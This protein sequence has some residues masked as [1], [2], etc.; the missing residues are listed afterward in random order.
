MDRD[1]A[2]QLLVGPA[3]AA[4]YGDGPDAG[5][6]RG[7]D[8]IGGVPHHEDACLRQVE[9]REG[10][11]DHPRIGLGARGIGRGHP[12][13]DQVAHPCDA[14]QLREVAGFRGAGHDHAQAPCAQLLDE[15]TRSAERA[16]T[17]QVLASEEPAARA[18]R[19]LPDGRVVTESG[20]A[21]EE[22]VSAHADELAHDPVG[23][24]EAV[25]AQG[26]A[27]RARVLIV[28]VDEGPVDVEHDRSQA[29][30]VRR[31]RHVRLAASSVPGVGSGCAQ[32][33]HPVAQHFVEPD[34]CDAS[35]SSR[36]TGGS[37]AFRERS[38]RNC[39]R[40]AEREL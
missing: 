36:R 11:M 16:H 14:Q 6:G 17:V 34:S 4:A 12:E 39:G 26:R 21:R 2:D 23:R 28:A 37:C 35:P 19:R 31:A 33:R 3:S 27:P 32:G 1:R 13:F 22:L 24:A 10:R 38:R 40:R 5:Q 18:L 29:I 20:H 8:V 9:P 30:E 7:L 15:R 25:L